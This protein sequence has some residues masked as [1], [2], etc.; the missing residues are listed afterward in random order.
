MKNCEHTLLGIERN[1]P[2]TNFQACFVWFSIAGR[3]RSLDGIAK[4]DTNWNQFA[5]QIFNRF[6]MKNV[7]EL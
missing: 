3:P 2:K 5:W 7:I 6:F 4:F 1:F